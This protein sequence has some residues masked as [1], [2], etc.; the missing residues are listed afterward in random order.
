MSE[1]MPAVEY[2]F[3]KIVCKDPNV[4]DSYIGHTTNFKIRETKHK[5]VCNNGTVN[6]YDCFVYQFLRK[7]G[8]WDNWNMIIIHSQNCKSKGEAMVIERGYIE[9]LG[10][11]LHRNLPSKTIEEYNATVAISQKYKE[12]AKERAKKNYEKNK[13]NK[14]NKLNTRR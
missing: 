2:I 10:A 7:S 9:S 11:S 8:G 14:L 4:I 13:L 1:E 6:G 5:G 3:Y 12:K